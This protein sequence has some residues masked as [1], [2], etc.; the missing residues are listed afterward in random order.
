MNVDF[1]MMANFLG[2]EAF[3][4]GI[5]NYLNLHKFGNAKQVSIF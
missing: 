1:R 2:L 5:T 3:N 4:A